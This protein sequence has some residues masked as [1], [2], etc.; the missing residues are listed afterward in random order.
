MQQAS[1]KQNCAILKLVVA[2]VTRLVTPFCLSVTLYPQRKSDLRFKKT[3]IFYKD[4]LFLR[5]SPEQMI[6]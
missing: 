3:L 6:F 1:R 4:G 5:Q 2:E